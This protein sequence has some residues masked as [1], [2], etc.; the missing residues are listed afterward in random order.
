MNTLP[1]GSKQLPLYPGG[2]VENVYIVKFDQNGV[3]GVFNTLF[4][5]CKITAAF[6]EEGMSD[7]ACEIKSHDSYVLLAVKFGTTMDDEPYVVTLI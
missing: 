1:S 3:S 4:I 5:H 6:D 2:A 7:A